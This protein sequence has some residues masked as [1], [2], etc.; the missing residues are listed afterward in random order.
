MILKNNIRKDSEHH[1][2]HLV[3]VS[4]RPLF[5]SIFAF[6]FSIAFLQVDEFV[7]LLCIYITLK[8]K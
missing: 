2:F 8:K 6:Q 5:S 7:S 1:P 3:T 4:P